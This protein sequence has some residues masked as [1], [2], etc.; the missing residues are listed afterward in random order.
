VQRLVQKEKLVLQ[1]Q[2]ELDNLKSSNPVEVRESVRFSRIYMHLGLIFA[3]IPTTQLNRMNELSVNERKPSGLASWMKLPSLRLRSVS[4]WLESISY[5]LS[6]VSKGNG[7]RK[8][9]LTERQRATLL[10][11]GS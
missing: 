9:Y 1:L 8:Y 2:S 6:S 5:S 3:Y 10:E 4:H 7:S 11:A